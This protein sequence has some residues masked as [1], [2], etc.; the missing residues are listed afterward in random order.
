MRGSGRACGW[1]G[2]LA[3]FVLYRWVCYTCARACVCGE[4]KRLCLSHTL[5]RRTVKANPSGSGSKPPSP[6]P[7]NLQVS[8]SSMNWPRGT[9]A[10]FN[11]HSLISPT[12]HRP[13]PS[14]NQAALGQE[15]W[16]GAGVCI[17]GEQRG[18][19]VEGE[20][21]DQRVSGLISQQQESTA[22]PP[23]L[24]EG[25]AGLVALQAGRR[26]AAALAAGGLGLCVC[27]EGCIDS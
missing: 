11:G 7:E 5:A 26:G 16:G 22:P 4:S 27:V 23:H 10:T 8:T 20:R 1:V 21:V 9:N 19:P 14:T 6:L 18:W 12:P 3:S 17:G 15:A 13:W 2:S 25:A 24:I